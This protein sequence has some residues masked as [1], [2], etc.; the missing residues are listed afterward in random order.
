[1]WHLRHISCQPIH[2]KLRMWTSWRKV[3]ESP[4]VITDLLSGNDEKSEQNLVQIHP[5]DDE[6]FHWMSKKKLI[7]SGSPKSVGFNLCLSLDISTKFQVICPI[8][9]EIFQSGGDSHTKRLRWHAA[10]N[11]NITITG[12]RI[13]PECRLS[14]SMFSLGCNQHW[15]LQD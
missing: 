6:I 9:V 13:K 10:M 3:S 11:S 5:A 8:V 2:L 1:M 15:T 4:K 12:M 7:C 14:M